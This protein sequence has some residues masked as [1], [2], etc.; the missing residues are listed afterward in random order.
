MLDSF[1]SCTA[2]SY[3]VF[4][5]FFRE[6]NGKVE[7]LLKWIGYGD[8]DN[9]WEPV[10]ALDCHELIAEFEKKRKEAEPERK[11][12]SES[13][14]K[15]PNEAKTKKQTDGKEKKRTSSTKD[16]DQPPP[17]KVSERKE[18]EEVIMYLATKYSNCQSNHYFCIEMALC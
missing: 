13:K 2:D 8:D 12:P 15:K 1:P 16:L 11:K 9:T 18:A 17:E 3:H 10:E 5:F 7:Y 4:E 6:V 14:T